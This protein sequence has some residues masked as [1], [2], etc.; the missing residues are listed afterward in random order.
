M[1]L[2][3]Y[4]AFL[5]LGFEPTDHSIIVDDS[6]TSSELLVAYLL[7]VEEN[8]LR[9]IFKIRKSI[10]QSLFDYESKLPKKSWHETLFRGMG[11]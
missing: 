7:G 3:E 11:E 1:T 5:R 2:K 10:E 9:R 8:N 4:V 6:I